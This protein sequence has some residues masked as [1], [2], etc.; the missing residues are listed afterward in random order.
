MKSINLNYNI[1][2]RVPEGSYSQTGVWAGV[3]RYCLLLC[4]SG[5]TGTDVILWVGKNQHFLIWKKGILSVGGSLDIV[6]AHEKQVQYEWREIHTEIY[7]LFYRGDRAKGILLVREDGGKRLHTKPAPEQ[8]I[9]IDWGAV[10]ANM[11]IAPSHEERSCE[12]EE[13]LL[14]WSMVLA[15][16]F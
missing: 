5:K 6:H 14:I 3:E 10:K 1:W 8:L 9:F 11:H 4:I 12:Q 13:F 2:G 15:L 7:I 16:F